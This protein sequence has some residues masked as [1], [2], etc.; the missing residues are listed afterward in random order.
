MCVIHY[1]LKKNPPKPAFNST[2]CQPSYRV[3]MSSSG[4]LLM[5]KENRSLIMNLLHIQTHEQ[6][7]CNNS[8][9]AV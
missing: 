7:L 3:R 4:L 1:D 2:F 9:S 6:G 5:L 8:F